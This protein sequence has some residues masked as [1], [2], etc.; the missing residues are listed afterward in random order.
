MR[1]HP[2]ILPSQRNSLAEARR[3]VDGCKYPRCFYYKPGAKTYCCD[4]CS[5]DHFDYDRL[6]EEEKSDG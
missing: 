1:F 3:K 2:E 5:G 4:A 6:K